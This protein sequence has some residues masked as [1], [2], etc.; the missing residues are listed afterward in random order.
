MLIKLMYEILFVSVFLPLCA[1]LVL[2]QEFG[3]IIVPEQGFDKKYLPENIVW[4]LVK[5]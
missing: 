2:N 5:C 3:P 4:L 1:L